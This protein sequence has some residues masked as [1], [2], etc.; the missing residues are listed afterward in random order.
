MA[1]SEVTYRPSQ[2]LKPA[3]DPSLKTGT[4]QEFERLT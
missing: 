4:F 1:T 3:P 2:N